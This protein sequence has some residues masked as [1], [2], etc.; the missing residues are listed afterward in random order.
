MKFYKTQ[1]EGSIT[2]GVMARDGDVLYVYL[3]NTDLWHRSP[4]LA[5]DF[6]FE[7]EGI[8]T[9]VMPEEVPALIAGV[10]R[11][12]ERGA[13]GLHVRRRQSQPVE[14]IRTSTALGLITGKRQATAKGNLLYLARAAMNRW[15]PV[16]RYPE[17]EVQSA[18]QLKHELANDQKVSYR[19]I[20]FFDV[21][22]IKIPQGNFTEVQVKK[23]TRAI[24]KATAESE[25]KT[26][27]G[28]I[29]KSKGTVHH[30]SGTSETVI[31]GRNGSIR[32]AEVDDARQATTTAD[33]SNW[34]R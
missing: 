33:T 20:G 19:E 1:A 27:A 12:D 21:R 32:G 14:D 6:Y 24:E 9:E 4:E 2:H 7:Q 28:I 30:K 10:Q 23:L 13:G 25:V 5:T 34:R 8:Y 31:Q 18:R 15:I 29:R 22:L 3:P 26:R 16:A 11:I 17:A